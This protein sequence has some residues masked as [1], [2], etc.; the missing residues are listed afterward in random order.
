MAVY[1]TIPGAVV[2][3]PKDEIELKDMMY[4]AMLSEHG[5]FIIR[6]PRGNG[7]GV[8]WEDHEFALMP[9]GR[10]EMLLGG[11]DVAV[12]GAG[13]V[14]NRALE[15]A[16]EMKADMGVN[17]SIY[18]IRYIKPIDDFTLAICQM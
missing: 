14:V 9:E 5:P 8:A 1:R 16:L 11:K 12:I 3:A 15:A 18:N 4:T 2:A 6:Y 7:E 10:G 13:P 17:P